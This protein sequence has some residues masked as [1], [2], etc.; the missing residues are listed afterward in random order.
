MQQNGRGFDQDT[1]RELRF[2]VEF[3]L[4]PLR[5]FALATCAGHIE[6]AVE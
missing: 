3:S 1:D 5:P 6:P 2:S 4:I